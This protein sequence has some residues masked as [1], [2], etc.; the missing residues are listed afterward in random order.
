MWTAFSSALTRHVPEGVPVALLNY[1]NHSNVGDCAIWLGEL[2][3]LA[4]TGHEVVYQCDLHSYDPDVLRRKL[5]DDG[6]VLLHGGGNL[7]DLWPVHQRFRE[8]VVADLPSL[9]VVIMPQTVHFTSGAAADRARAA[10]SRH[11]R[12]TV[13]A[14]DEESHG[15]ARDAFT[16]AI[17]LAPD[18][19][20]WLDLQHARLAP[21]QP[22][23]WL[24][25]T[26]IEAAGR[27]H[28][29]TDTVDWITARRSDMG[30][31]GSAQYRLLKHATGLLARTRGHRSPLRPIQRSLYEPVASAHLKRG[32]GL[33]STGEVVIADR[34]HAHILCLL[35]GIP[36]VMLDNNYGKLTRYANTWTSQSRLANW[37]R[38]L[39]EALTM[40]NELAF[41]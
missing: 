1:P 18:P 24:S 28:G 29:R 36:H 13:I 19:A 15:L 23:V 40:A 8:R 17:D 31:I 27:H 5:P 25:R 11:D 26:D 10:F 4:D 22:I 12:L 6:I 7:G 20:I 33:L 30:W 39:S 32:I 9:P 2:A 41:R 38:D 34:L 14:R 3:Y 16:C 21:T 35:L 37:A